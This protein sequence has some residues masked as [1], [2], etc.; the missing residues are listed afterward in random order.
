MKPSKLKNKIRKKMMKM[1][2]IKKKNDNLKNH[3]KIFSLKIE[4]QKMKKYKIIMI[5][6]Y[7]IY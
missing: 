1:I 7:I 2:M 4:N 6:I 3:S 5:D